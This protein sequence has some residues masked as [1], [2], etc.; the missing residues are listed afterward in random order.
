MTHKKSQQVIF[1]TNIPAPYRVDFF[2]ELHKQYALK[3]I[4]YAKDM[5]VMGWKDSNKS[6]DFEYVFLFGKSKFGW[7]SDLYQ[8]IKNNQKAIFVVGGYSLLPEMLSILFLKCL[9]R[10]FLLNLDGGFIRKKTFKTILKNKLIKSASYCLSS[11]I[12]TTNTLIHYGAKPEKIWEYHFSSLFKKEVLKEPVSKTEKESL[13]LKWNLNKNHF[14]LIYV[15]QLIDRK[16]VDV[17]LNALTKVQSNVALLIVGD[18]VN[19]NALSDFAKQNNLQDKI[20][21]LGTQSKEN[22]LELLKLSDTFVLPTR[23]DI[24]GLV[25]NEAIACGLPVITTKQTGAAYSL[26]EEGKNGYLYDCNQADRLSFYI[27]SIYKDDLVAF[28]KVSLQMA[29]KYT[30]E[31]MVADHVELFDKIKK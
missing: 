10:D 4:F 19:R 29:N 6:Y 23:E 20:H 8:L 28:S 9:K 24:W 22:V 1:L 5:G 30:I 7:I 17:L 16:G 13:R 15:G 2:N 18:G 21:F 26:I 12:N 27:D 3:V 25:V 31:Q 14:Y 11:G